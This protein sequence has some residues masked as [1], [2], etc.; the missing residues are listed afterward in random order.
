M[1]TEHEVLFR[2]AN[3]FINITHKQRLD[4]GLK[5]G[6]VGVAALMYSP[7]HLQEVVFVQAYKAKKLEGL[8]R[9]IE[10][11]KNAANK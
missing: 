10:N 11:L 7:D 2:I 5:L 9:A 8:C 6:L 1:N 3:A 4:I